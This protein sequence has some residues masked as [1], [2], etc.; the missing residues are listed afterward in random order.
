MH[1]VSQCI[2]QCWEW[3]AH[4]QSTLL[5]FEEKRRVVWPSMHW[6]QVISMFLYLNADLITSSEQFMRKTDNYKGLTYFFPL[7]LLVVSEKWKW[8]IGEGWPLTQT[9]DE[10]GYVCMNR[11]WSS[12]Y[13]TL[14]APPP[15]PQLSIPPPNEMTPYTIWWGI[16]IHDCM[17]RHTHTQ[18]DFEH[19][20][21]HTRTH[22]LPLIRWHH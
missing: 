18:Q 12:L 5:A 3:L 21:T 11:H 19:T 9:E 2:S 15:L 14:P 8:K 1:L 20:N 13:S 22:P 17:H 4:K 16:F 7:P 10:D 6:A